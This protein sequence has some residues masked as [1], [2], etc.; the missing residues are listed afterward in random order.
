MTPVISYRVIAVK[1]KPSDHKHGSNLCTFGASQRFSTLGFHCKLAA[2]L[3]IILFISSSVSP[4][5][6]P[7]KV[8]IVQWKIC[9]KV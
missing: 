4:L 2:S 1:L 5:C 6:E 8:K 3:K 7:H 9:A